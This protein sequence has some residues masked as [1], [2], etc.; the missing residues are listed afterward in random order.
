MNKF[1]LV[2]LA[3]IST[4]SLAGEFKV[5]LYAEK[6]NKVSGSHTEQV[7]Q[8]YDGY[9]V[10]NNDYYTIEGGYHLRVGPEYYCCKEVAYNNDLDYISIG[11]ADYGYSVNVA[12][13]KD[14]YNERVYSVSAYKVLK[15][16]SSVNFSF[17]VTIDDSMSVS[18]SLVLSYDEYFTVPSLEINKDNVSVVLSARF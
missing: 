14:A 13:Y 3:V 7:Q 5:G 2:M 18:P 9:P 11:Y 16:E 10:I 4:Q 1:I 12:T 17:G 8:Y 6:V 15:G